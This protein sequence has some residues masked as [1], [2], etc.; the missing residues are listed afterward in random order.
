MIYTI[1]TW[2]SDMYYALDDG[3]IHNASTGSVY[4]SEFLYKMK[5]EHTELVIHPNIRYNANGC[6]CSLSNIRFTEFN[7]IKD[8]PKWFYNYDVR[9]P[10]I[11]QLSEDDFESFV[12]MNG[13]HDKE[14]YIKNG[15][16]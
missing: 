13:R 8:I 4:I 15:Y 7:S 6:G 14:W 11:K 1:K 3:K 5:I 12:M 10:L 16:R 2:N 9:K